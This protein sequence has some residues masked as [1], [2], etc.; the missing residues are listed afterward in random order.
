MGPVDTIAHPLWD[1]NRDLQESTNSD[2]HAS[3]QGLQDSAAVPSWVA[4]S[5]RSR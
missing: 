5:S 1:A 2:L 3:L 4:E